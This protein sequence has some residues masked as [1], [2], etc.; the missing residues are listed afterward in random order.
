VTESY[1]AAVARRW[2]AAAF[3]AAPRPAVFRYLA[4][5]RNRPEWQAS[6]RGVELL[7]EGEPYV[8]MRWVDQVKAGPSF[9]LQIIG[10]EPDRMW[11]EVGSAGPFTAFGTLLFEDDICGGVDGTT[12]RCVARVRA[13]RFAKPLGIPATAVAGLLVRNDLARAARI[14]EG[15]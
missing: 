2:D 9:Q 5:P 6:L 4:D 14:I 11:A 13:R 7:D 10:M 1:G 8:G 3:V 12:V 15:R